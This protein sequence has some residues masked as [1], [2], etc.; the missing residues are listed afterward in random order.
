M[1]ERLRSEGGPVLHRWCGGLARGL[2]F[3]ITVFWNVGV[4]QRDWCD[5]LRAR[6]R[7]SGEQEMVGDEP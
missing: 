2:A 5:A 1:T 7:H 3:D 6:Q 4:T